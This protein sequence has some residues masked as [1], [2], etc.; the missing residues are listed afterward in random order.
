MNAEQ[1][2]ARI[3]VLDTKI[4]EKEKE[5]QQAITVGNFDREN[6]LRAEK[7]ALIEERVF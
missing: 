4:E 2:L 1:V 3:T 5:I 7:T 6:S